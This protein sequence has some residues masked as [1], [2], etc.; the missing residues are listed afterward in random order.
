MRKEELVRFITSRLARFVF[1]L[2]NCGSS[3]KR[4]EVKKQIFRRFA[5]VFHAFKAAKAMLPSKPEDCNKGILQREAFARF[6]LRYDLLSELAAQLDTGCGGGPS[7]R[8]E[9][10]DGLVE[11]LW[12]VLS[13]RADRARPPGIT[14]S[15]R[16]EQEL[17][18]PEEEVD[19]DAAR[20]AA[21]FGRDIRNGE[22]TRRRRRCSRPHC[23]S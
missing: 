22:V 4:I 5:S 1:F 13:K 18:Q 11:T 7:S 8:G 16:A 2:V 10:V 19:V 12:T 6:L 17:E 3:R 20:F 21:I 23:R 14:S 15:T 9:I